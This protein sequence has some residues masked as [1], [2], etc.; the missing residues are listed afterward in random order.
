[1]IYT[2]FPKDGTA[3]AVQTAETETRKTCTMRADIGNKFNRPQYQDSC[4][5]RG[6]I[7]VLFG[8][9][10]YRGWFFLQRFSGERKAS[11]T[12]VQHRRLSLRCANS[13]DAL[14]CE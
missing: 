6:L 4:L 1:M 9:L 14:R 3:A 2:E 12:R 10:I 8:R 13:C 7:S 11:S 5:P